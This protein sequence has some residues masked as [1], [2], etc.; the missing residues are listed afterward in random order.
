M[1]KKGKARDIWNGIP[2][3]WGIPTIGQDG[4]SYTNLYIEDPTNPK[5]GKTVPNSGHTQIAVTNPA[6]LAGRIHAA[7]ARLVEEHQNYFFSQFKA[8]KFDSMTFNYY[9]TVRWD[10]FAADAWPTSGGSL[11]NKELWKTH[12]ELTLGNMPFKS[13]LTEHG[14]HEAMDNIWARSTNKR[15]LTNDERSCWF[16]LEH[17]FNDA[18]KLGLVENNPA[19]KYAVKYRESQ[20]TKALANLNRCDLT[21]DELILI[22][23]DAA[24][25]LFQGYLDGAIILLVIFL[26]L[27]IYE[28]CG[29]DLNHISN[30]I[31]EIQISQEYYQ[32]RGETPQL[33]QCLRYSQYRRIPCSRLIKSIL[34]LAKKFRPSV[35]EDQSALFVDTTGKR[36]TPEAVKKLARDLQSKYLI[37]YDKMS[38]GGKESSGTNRLGLLSGTASYY[39]RHTCEMELD[40]IQYI[41]GNQRET[42]IG[43][44]YISWSSEEFAHPPLLQKMEIWHNQYLN[45][46]LGKAVSLQKKDLFIYVVTGLAHAH[47][48]LSVN[49]SS[50]VSICLPASQK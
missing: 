38:V 50:G 4:R 19:K 25:R 42:T 39:F 34:R 36:I 21:D 46:L 29:L 3:H 31:S 43:E 15:E 12:L 14:L 10:F 32:K 5:E 17:I 47:A 26:D 22:C 1:D 9:V 41:L 23:D 45:L 37:T 49:S 33:R 44:W 35:S 8:G 40:E 24:T 16:L 7:M 18:E 11:K 30:S 28:V 20:R 48:T 13:L 27:N 6:D 2:F